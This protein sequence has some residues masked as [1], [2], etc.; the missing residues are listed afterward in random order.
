MKKYLIFTILFMVLFAFQSTEI[1]AGAFKTLTVSLDRKEL[2]TPQDGPDY[3]PP[4]HR[5]PADAY[6]CS[7]TPENGVEISGTTDEIIS[8]EI[9]DATGT[10]CIAYFTNEE[11]FVEYLF[12][13]NGDFQLVFFF[14]DYTLTGEITVD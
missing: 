3:D 4:I 10:V 6:I 13:L 7:I 2:I 8:Y 1:F 9:W 5:S 12:S 11:E 14:E